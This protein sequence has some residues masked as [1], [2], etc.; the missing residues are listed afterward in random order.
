MG[1]GSSRLAGL[2]IEGFRLWGAGQ[3]GRLVFRVKKLGVWCR[4]LVRCVGESRGVKDGGTGLGKGI[5]G[6]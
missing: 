3:G 6:L 5:L 1:S 2:S 4:G